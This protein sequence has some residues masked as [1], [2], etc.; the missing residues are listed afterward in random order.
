MIRKQ[1]KGLLTFSPRNKNSNLLDVMYVFLSGLDMHLDIFLLLDLIKYDSMKQKHYRLCE[2]SKPTSS[3]MIIPK[4]CFL[5]FSQMK[6]LIS[7]ALKNEMNK[8]CFEFA[9]NGS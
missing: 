5:L 1:S 4:G 8:L 3:N 2:K 7:S 6:F 9:S